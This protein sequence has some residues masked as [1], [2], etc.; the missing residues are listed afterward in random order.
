MNTPISAHG[1][2]A[3]IQSWFHETQLANS[4]QQTA[5]QCLPNHVSELGLGACICKPFTSELRSLNVARNSPKHRQNHVETKITY[6]PRISPPPSSLSDLRI[7]GKGFM[8]MSEMA[9][10]GELSIKISASCRSH[11]VWPI[12]I[13]PPADH[14]PNLSLRKASSGRIKPHLGNAAAAATSRQCPAARKPSRFWS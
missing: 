11:I 5:C 4:F 9:R 1:L 14:G 13:T 8:K 7:G 2:K 12:L 10:W 3:A 6:R